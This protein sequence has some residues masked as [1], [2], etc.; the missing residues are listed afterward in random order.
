MVSATPASSNI[1]GSGTTARPGAVAPTARPT[2]AR[3]PI[4]V[5]PTA[6]TTRRPSS[7]APQTVPTTRAPLSTTVLP[8][9]ETERLITDFGTG[10]QAGTNFFPA[11]SSNNN[12]NNG[13][14]LLLLGLL[15]LLG[16]FALSNNP[17]QPAV[18]PPIAPP[19]FFVPSIPSMYTGSN[20]GY[21]SFGLLPGGVPVLSGFEVQSGSY[22]NYGSNGAGKYGS[23]YGNKYGN[24]HY[25]AATSYGENYGGNKAV[26]TGMVNNALFSQTLLANS[27]TGVNLP[28]TWQQSSGISNTGFSSGALYNTGGG[29]QYNVG[30]LSTGSNGVLPNP[31]WN[32]A[33]VGNN[34]Y[35]SQSALSG[36][37]WNN[38]DKIN[39]GNMATN[40]ATTVN[41]NNFAIGGGQTQNFGTS[42][43]VNPSSVPKGQWSGNSVNWN[44]NGLGGNNGLVS[45]IAYPQQGHIRGKRG[46]SGGY[47]HQ[48]G[49]GPKNAMQNAGTNPRQF[50]NA[51]GTQVQQSFGSPQFDP[52]SPR[53]GQFPIPGN[54]ENGRVSPYPGQ[55]NMQNGEVPSGQRTNGEVRF[56]DRN[57][58]P[59]VHDW[60]AL[61]MQRMQAQAK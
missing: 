16:A 58:R 60:Y 30:V 51:P 28:S 45:N 24:N 25:T 1:D 33:N 37:Q 9:P 29:S 8:S 3:P 7:S 40:L 4:F 61:L 42:G 59:Q 47:Q 36:Q 57:R 20:F 5:I 19:G 35:Y 10:A 48:Q 17:R 34:G 43:F 11:S 27:L 13:R 44:G 6:F 26:T 32:A 38:W 56:F 14:L 49:Y 2:T 23:G 15:P 39:S 21:G 55:S 46:T 18:I 50:I 31:G 54:T 22:G 12:N 41:N 52:N 53:G